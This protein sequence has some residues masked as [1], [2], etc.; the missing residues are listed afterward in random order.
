MFANINFESDSMGALRNTF[1]NT[2]VNG[3]YFHH[4]QGIFKKIQELGLR[5]NYLESL[6]DDSTSAQ[7]WI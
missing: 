3:C 1:P 5:K 4:N 2:S 6:T 7:Q